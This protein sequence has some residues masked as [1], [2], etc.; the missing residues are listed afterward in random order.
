VESEWG[1]STAGV[2]ILQQAQYYSRIYLTNLMCKVPISVLY[3]WQDDGTNLSN[4]EDCFGVIQNG[5][6]LRSDGGTLEGTGVYFIK[7]SYYALYETAY[8]LNGYTFSESLDAVSYLPHYAYA[9]SPY[10]YLLRF[11]NGGSV[12]YALWSTE[13]PISLNLPASLFNCSLIRAVNAFGSAQI[14]AAN[15]CFEVTATQTPQF[16]YPA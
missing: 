2:T 8:S 13:G 15:P 7:P 12:K 1:Y 14:I 5:A 6:Q 4:G 10:V 11:V 16:L 9:S 3:D